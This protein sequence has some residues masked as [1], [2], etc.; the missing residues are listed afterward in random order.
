LEF[1][2]FGSEKV[3]EFLIASEVRDSKI[4]T[5]GFSKKPL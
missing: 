2:S 1:E 3:M 5:L 4:S